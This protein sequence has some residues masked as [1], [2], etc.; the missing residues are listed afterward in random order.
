ME[1][2]HVRLLGMSPMT[3]AIEVKETLPSGGYGITAYIFQSLSGGEG[4][5]EMLEKMAQ[6]ANMKGVEFHAKDSSQSV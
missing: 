3:I 6:L 4:T 5:L 1:P 2:Y